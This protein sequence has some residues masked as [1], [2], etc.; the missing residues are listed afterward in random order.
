MSKEL[1]ELAAKAM[2]ATK[3]PRFCNYTVIDDDT[4]CL[5]LGHCRG[6]I[7]AYW[8]PL[9]NDSDAFRMSVHLGIDIIQ[10]TKLHEGITECVAF[11]EGGCVPVSYRDDPYAATRR[12]IVKAAAEIGKTI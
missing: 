4:V 2:Q 7:T 12:A 3:H 10:H 6:S 5:E 1:L 9:T 11:Y 8:H